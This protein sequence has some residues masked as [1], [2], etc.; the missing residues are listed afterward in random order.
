M[1]LTVNPKPMTSSSALTAAHVQHLQSDLGLSTCKTNIAVRDLRSSLD[2]SMVQSSIGR[3]LLVLDH[4]LD[5]LFEVRELPFVRE[6]SGM[7]APAA[8]FVIVCT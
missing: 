8:R 3:E 7:S 6:D 5:G 1:R 4:E 2:S